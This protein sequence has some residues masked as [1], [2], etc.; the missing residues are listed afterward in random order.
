MNVRLDGADVVGEWAKMK[1]FYGERGISVVEK[2]VNLVPRPSN[3]LRFTERYGPLSF[4]AW[5]DYPDEFRF[6]IDSWQLEQRNFRSSWK[7]VQSHGV[8]RGAPHEMIR[9]EFGPKQLA[10][11]CPDIKTFMELELESQAEKLRVCEREDCK[12]PYFIPQ[13]GKERYCSTDCSNW[14]QS[15]WKKRWH[16]KQREKRIKKEKGDGAQKAR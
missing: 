3:I 10:I 11:Q 5:G 8:N 15:Q 7:W 9:L 6:S 14:A 13:H 16:E 4:L 12:N 2:F 1:N